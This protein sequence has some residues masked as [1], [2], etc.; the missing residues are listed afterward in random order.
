MHVFF[1]SAVASNLTTG[2]PIIS[3]VSL[4]PEMEMICEMWVMKNH[5]RKRP[6]PPPPPPPHSQPH[7]H[8]HIIKDVWTA[9]FVKLTLR[10]GVSKKN[11]CNPTFSVVLFFLWLSGGEICFNIVP[12]GKI[13][14]KKHRC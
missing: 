8:I 12:T 10:Q 11:Y 7:L 14:E 3:Q 4:I 13:K 9:P 6:A 5:L 2:L 1:K